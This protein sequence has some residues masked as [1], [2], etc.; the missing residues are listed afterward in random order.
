[1]LSRDAAP[2]QLV[3]GVFSHVYSVESNTTSGSIAS[4]PIM[5]AGLRRLR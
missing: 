5:V 3:A 1:M 2:G 4:S